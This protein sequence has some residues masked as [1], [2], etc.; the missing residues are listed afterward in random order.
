MSA[1]P[2]TEDQL[3]DLQWQTFH[4]YLRE[5]NEANGLVADK[6]EPGSPCSIAAVGMSLATQPILV[7]R[8]LLPRELLARRALRK[9]RF[10]WNSLQGREPDA[11]GYKGFY[12]H[13]LDMQTGRRVG[14]CELSTIDSAFLIAGFL[15]AASYF[16]G[17]TAEEHEIRTLADA[18]Y[19]RVDWRWALNDGATVT[20]GWKP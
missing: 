15:T 12:Y 10:F 11:T 5:V 8:M 3:D 4:Y 20:H 7:E 6:T 19:R 1:E 9:L 13:F 2:I 16:D 18:L 17:D 14:N